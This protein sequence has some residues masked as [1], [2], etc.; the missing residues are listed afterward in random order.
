MTFDWMIDYKI[1]YIF[2]LEFAIGNLFM[3]VPLP[4]FMI[5]IIIGVNVLLTSFITLI[6]GFMSLFLLIILFHLGISNSLVNYY[7]NLQF[8]YLTVS[9]N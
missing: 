4:E 2:V 1:V 3:S 9:S 7:I 6:R 8:H 5:F